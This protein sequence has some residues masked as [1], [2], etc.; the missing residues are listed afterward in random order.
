MRVGGTQEGQERRVGSN[1]K[2]REKGGRRRRN[3]RIGNDETKKDKQSSY[4]AMAILKVF[5][6]YDK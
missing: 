6:K 5:M 3:V 2:S 4:R 1:G